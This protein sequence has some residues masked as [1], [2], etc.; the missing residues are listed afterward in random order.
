MSKI[1]DD[2]ILTDAQNF[3]ISLENPFEFIFTWMSRK[4]SAITVGPLSMGF[5]DPL[6]IRP[7]MSSETGVR[8]MSPVNSQVVFLA[9]IPDVPSKT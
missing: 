9:S 3:Y 5:P 1:L 6:K 2:L 8:K 7:S 4:S